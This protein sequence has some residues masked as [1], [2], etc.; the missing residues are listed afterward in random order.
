MKN[1]LKFLAIILLAAGV[2]VGTTYFVNRKSSSATT[3]SQLVQYSGNMTSSS[4]APITPSV[5]SVS[6]NFDFTHAAEKT[7]N[8]VVHVKTTYNIR[9]QSADPFLEFFFGRPLQQEPRYQQ[10]SGSGVIIS[11][12]GYIVT[13]NHVIAKARDI[14]VVLNDKRTYSASLVGTDPNTDIALLKIEETNLPWM[15]FGNSDSLRVGEWVLAV[16]NPFNLTS[17]VTAGIVSAK[18]RNINIIDSDMKIESF[19]Q[20]DAAVNPGNSGGALVN[21]RGKL[22]GINTA[23]ASQTGSY[24]GYSF[25][26]PITIVNK[27]VSDLKMYGTVQR[28]LMGIQIADITDEM[29]K[30]LNLTTMQ[31]VYVGNVIQG[32]AAAKAGLQIGDVIIAIDGR[33][34]SSTAELQE[35]VGRHRP[36]DTIQVQYIRNGQTNVTILQLQ[37]LKQQI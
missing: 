8:A 5:S 23:I 4:A 35:T 7:V 18:A 30:T 10:A 6:G 11:Q 16:G 15:E 28:G 26:V 3:S 32:S 31:G 27:V 25:A 29:K 13:N 1:V 2:S 17:T 14:Q 19:I 36:G 24:T 20:T 22:V 34:I 21:T 37:A 33:S 9:Q 12:D